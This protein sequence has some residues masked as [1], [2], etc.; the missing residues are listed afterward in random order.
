MVVSALSDAALRD[1]LP[2]ACCSAIGAAF[3][4][5]LFTTLQPEVMLYTTEQEIHQY[6]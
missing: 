2:K 4:E 1:F 6:K 5:F 3:R